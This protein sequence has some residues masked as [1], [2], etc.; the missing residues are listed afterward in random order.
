[1][2]PGKY[3]V[4]SSERDR[5]GRETAEVDRADGHGGFMDLIRPRGG[6]EAGA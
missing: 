5:A 3:S 4:K 1:M 2:G 6:E